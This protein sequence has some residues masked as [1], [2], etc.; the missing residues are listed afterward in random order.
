MA[1]YALSF[2]L[3]SSK[4]SEG[5]STQIV[6]CLH[7]GDTNYAAATGYDI[8]TAAADFTPVDSN[9]NNVIMNGLDLIDN[10]GADA[11]GDVHVILEGGG[12]KILPFK[13]LAGESKRAFWGERIKTIVETTTTFTGGIFPNW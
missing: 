7:S 3:S 8:A 13:V 2:N 12:E 10:A 1:N 9:G 11:A 6:D 5:K 4:R